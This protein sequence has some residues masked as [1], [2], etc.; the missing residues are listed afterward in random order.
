MTRVKHFCV[1]PV[2]KTEVSSGRRY[3]NFGWRLKKYLIL[4]AP[5]AVTGVWSC[6]NVLYV[7]ISVYCLIFG[8]PKMQM[9]KKGLAREIMMGYWLYERREH[10][11]DTVV[12]RTVR[13]IFFKY[14]INSFDFTQLVL[15]LLWILFL[16]THQV[17]RIFFSN[18]FLIF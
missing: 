7:P 18:F 12:F 8:W 1:C 2:E 14:I 16:L 13:P 6:I 5:P 10:N 17:L 11:K 4:H 15:V 3:Y 9:N